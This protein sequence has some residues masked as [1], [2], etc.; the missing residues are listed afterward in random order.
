MRDNFQGNMMTA[1]SMDASCYYEQG[2]QYDSG[3]DVSSLNRM[4][5]LGPVQL[6]P[7][8]CDCSR[9]KWRGDEKPCVQKYVTINEMKKHYN[10]RL[11]SETLDL[12]AQK[13]AI[14]G[15]MQSDFRAA[16]KVKDEEARA[17][18]SQHNTFMAS[19]PKESRAGKERRLQQKQ[20]DLLDKCSNRTV[21][22]VGFKK[23]VIKDTPIEVVTARRALRRKESRDNKKKEELERAANFTVKASAVEVSATEEAVETSASEVISIDASASE[24]ASSVVT[25]ATEVASTVEAVVTS[26]TETSDVSQEVK[27]PHAKKSVAL[28]NPTH[29]LAQ[30]CRSVGTT[31]PCRHGSSCR[32]AHDTSK[33][34][35][36][37]GVDCRNVVCQESG[38]YKTTAKTVCSSLDDEL[39][40]RVPKELALQ[41]MEIAMKLGK[42]NIRIEIV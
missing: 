25:S 1:N 37:L 22:K 31:E 33:L 19:L 13:L 17:L 21:R 27:K 2:D 11:V 12:Q 20:K 42:T 23:R 8:H 16:M 26:A 40:I 4:R 14:I 29:K 24:V 10:D 34:D 7:K 30:M 38:V 5:I 35:Y 18:L 15:Q 9:C 41:A 39:V 36:N 28:P 32:F 3:E 6:A